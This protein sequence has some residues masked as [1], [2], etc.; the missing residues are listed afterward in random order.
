LSIPPS[1][2]LFP[3]TTL[4]RSKFC[5]GVAFIIVNMLTLIMRGDRQRKCQHEHQEHQ[6]TDYS[7]HGSLHSLDRC[8]S[9][10]KMTA[11]ISPTDR[12]DRKSTRLNS[13]HVKISYA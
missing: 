12:L 8:C 13:S 4:F 2:T 9:H 3:Y 7:V 1:S 5:F 10:Y 6:T 11:I